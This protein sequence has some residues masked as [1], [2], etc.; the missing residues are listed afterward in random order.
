M[1]EKIFTPAQSRKIVDTL[2]I[3]YNDYLNERITKY[4]EMAVSDGYAWTKANHIDDAFAK[5]YEKGELDF[6]KNFELEKAGES[7]GYLEFEGDTNLG[8]TL[9]IIK[10]MTRLS[11]TFEKT[12][13]RKPSQYLLD[14]A[15]I[16]K[17]F[18][19]KHIGDYEGLVEQVLLDIMP[20]KSSYK[21]SVESVR[22]NYDEFFVIVYESNSHAQLQSVQVVVL[23]PDTQTIVP[24][25]DL[26]MYLAESSITQ[27]EAPE[28]FEGKEQLPEGPGD[29]G[30]VAKSVPKEDE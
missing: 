11:Q 19:K 23:D 5:A 7:W 30:F 24:V 2:I 26:T 6:I 16:S 28:I 13:N 12:K 27:V 1:E 25:Q 21:V 14:Y 4:N 8:K 9:I 10:N 20:V 3:G 17:G 18:I 29:Y 22:E 15:Q